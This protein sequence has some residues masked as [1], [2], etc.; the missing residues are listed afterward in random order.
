MVLRARLSNV[1]NK[2]VRQMTI[3]TDLGNLHNSLK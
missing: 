3:L 1:C 2:M